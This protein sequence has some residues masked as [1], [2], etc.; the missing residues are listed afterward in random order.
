MR[1]LLVVG[2]LL[3]VVVGCAT[4]SPPSLVGDDDVP[5]PDASSVDARDIDARIIDAPAFQTITLSQTASNT[6]QAQASVA[7]TDTATGV[8]RE[9]S[10]YRV[11]RLADFGITRPFTATMVSF[12]VELAGAGNG[13]PSQNMQVKLYTLNGPL[14]LA[15]LAPIAGNNVVVPN[16]MISMINVP[17]VPAPRLLQS[18]ETLVAELFIPDGMALANVLFVGANNGTETATGYLRAPLCGITEPVTF[19]SIGFPQ[20]KLILTVTGTY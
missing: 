1:S 16:S 2:P 19:N 10:Y 17:L 9:N 12:G 3:A 6:V 7:C 11:F 14:S 4:A 18:N 5:D 15:G 8:I 13:L 20:V